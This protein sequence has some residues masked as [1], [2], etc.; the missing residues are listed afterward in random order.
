MD[1]VS[2][3]YWLLGCVPVRVDSRSVSYAALVPTRTAPGSVPAPLL[4]AP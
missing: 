2:E 4:P 1:W 3:Q